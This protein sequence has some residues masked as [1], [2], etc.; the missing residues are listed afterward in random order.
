MLPFFDFIKGVLRRVVSKERLKN[1]FDTDIISGSEMERAQELWRSIIN[2]TPDW[3]GRDDVETIGFAV[4]LC[5]DIAKKVCL[6]IGISAEGS[7]RAEFLQSAADGLLSVI[8]DKVQEACSCGGILMKPNGSHDPEDCIDYVT[9]FYVTKCNSNGD[10][11][12][13]IIPDCFVEGDVYYTRLEYHRFSDDGRYLIS[14]R[15]FRSRSKG[16][17]GRETEL[18]SVARW[19]HISPELPPIENVDRPL[20]AYFKMPYHNTIDASSPLGVPVFYNAVK[21]L[22]DLDIAWSRKSGEVE[23]SKHVT[24]L[25]QFLV[26]NAKQRK[27]RLPRF[28]MGADVGKLT[29]GAVH[30]HVA[31]LLTEQRIADINSILSMISTKCGFSQG[32]FVLDRKT[33]AVTA[34]QIESDDRETIETIKEMRDSL[35]T[36]VDGLLYALSK[37][38]DLYDL[39][40]VGEYETSYSFGDL[41]YNYEEDRARHWQYVQSGKYPLWRYFAK[42]EGMSEEEAKRVAEEAKSENS[43]RGLFD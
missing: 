34:T 2:G 26:Q 3:S 22:K 28:V 33:G 5:S 6:D 42:F 15:A 20:F 19:A 12:G 37:Y 38:A 18:S 31:T 13:V 25:P 30:E 35:K 23:D 4:F 29:E 41:T 24:F 1:I 7:Q 14:N 27:L 9:E 40:P 16:E 43:G 8:R 39:A 36:A 11:L 10:I 17:L 21:E 32:Q